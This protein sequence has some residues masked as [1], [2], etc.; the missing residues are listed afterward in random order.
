MANKVTMHFKNDRIDRAVYIAETVGFGEVF[1]T[2]VYPTQDIQITDTGVI[3]VVNHRGAIITT[4]IARVN[5]ILEIYK[6]QE[7]GN[8]PQWLLSKANKNWK[9][10]YTK[11][12]PDYH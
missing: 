4:Y 3:I 7:W 11:N 1:K 5:Q 8:A 9:K 12:Q 2:A 10:G 6:T